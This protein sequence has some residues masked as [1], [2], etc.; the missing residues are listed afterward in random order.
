MNTKWNFTIQDIK[1]VSDEILKEL[2]DLMNKDC[3]PGKFTLSE[4]RDKFAKTMDILYIQDGKSYIHF[5]LIDVFNKHKTV[6]LHDV[7]VS[8]HYRGQGIFKKSLLYLSKYYQKKGFHTITLDASDST[9][10]AGLDQKARIA[11]FARAG[12]TINP[13]TEVW[14]EKGEFNILDTKVLL[15]SG[16]S[17]TILNKRK[18]G[19]YSVRPTDSKETVSTIDISDIKKCYGL[20]DEYVSC[21]MIQTIPSNSGG[22]KR[23]TRKQRA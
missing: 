15:D 18:D 19:K 17:V 12:F 21:P 4:V 11:I 9:K 1:S 14:D 2:T 5:M 22:K 8:T 23:K 7:C 16:E 10:E 6:Y 13:K 20:N 3:Q